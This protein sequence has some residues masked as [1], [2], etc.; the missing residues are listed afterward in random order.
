MGKSLG[1]RELLP[2]TDCDQ[3]SA[4][5]QSIS[6]Y[7][8]CEVALLLAIVMNGA[9][10]S[11]PCT[12]II[13]VRSASEWDAGHVSCAQRLEIQNN[14][15]LISST[16]SCL[17]NQDLNYPIA[18]YCRSGNRAGV[19]VAAL[20]AAGYT[21]A[22]N[23]GG[24]DTSGSALEAQCTCNPQPTCTSTSTSASANGSVTSAKTWYPTVLA[25][26]AIIL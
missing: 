10:A 4:K 12:L 15:S 7:M 23:S 6:T 14:E 3:H 18:V 16:V 21:N 22:T 17:V 26:F 2:F 19:A 13:D 20:E 24:Y 5:H 9:S 11:A 25:L 8:G 1:L